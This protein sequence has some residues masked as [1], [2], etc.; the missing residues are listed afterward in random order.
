MTT[1][2]NPKERLREAAAA[3]DTG[4]DTLTIP[5]KTV[6]L[7]GGAYVSEEWDLV[8][9]SVGWATAGELRVLGHRWTTTAGWDAR[10]FHTF[11]HPRVAGTIGEALAAADALLA[12]LLDQHKNGTL[13]AADKG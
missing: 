3:A 6:Y 7:T 4:W 10:K 13:P 11:R 5:T 2:T 8:E 12:E 9:V 1:S